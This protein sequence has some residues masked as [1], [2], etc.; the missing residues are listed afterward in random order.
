MV[1]AEEKKIHPSDEFSGSVRCHI[2]NFARQKGEH[3]VSGSEI[4]RTLKDKPTSSSCETEFL[5]LPQIGRRDVNQYD[6][7]MKT[8]L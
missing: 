7:E 2:K 4:I 5:V 8:V 3:R 6:F 1:N